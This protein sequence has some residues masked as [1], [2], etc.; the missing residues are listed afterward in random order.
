M[1]NNT[2]ALLESGAAAA[3]GDYESIQTTTVGAGGT[4]TV[5][6]SSIPSTYKHLQIRMLSRTNRAFATDALKIRFNSDSGN[7]YAY[8]YLNGSG[9]AASAGALTSASLTYAP[10]PNMAGNSA[11][12]NIFGVTVTDVL[13]YANT[14]KY[15]TLRHLGGNDQN[16][17]GN[18]TLQS[19]LWLNT[20]AVSIIDITAEAGTTI[21]QYSSFALYGVK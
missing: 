19:G 5:T 21:L 14:N 15:K 13:D 9:S 20:A 4:S 17:S 12:A 2:V 16:G 10:T 6:F 7:N 1:L 3:V 11:S 8:H 18:V